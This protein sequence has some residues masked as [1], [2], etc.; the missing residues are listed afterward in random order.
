MAK[1][2]WR[3]FIVDRLTALPPEELLRI[4]TQLG[5]IEAVE[6][7]VRAPGEVYKLLLRRATAQHKEALLVTA[8]YRSL[9]Q[10]PPPADKLP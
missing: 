9:G 8:V 3:E 2:S 6:H 10:E 7:S 4:G 5:L 1:F